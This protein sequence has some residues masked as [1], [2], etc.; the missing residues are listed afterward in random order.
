MSRGPA[1][2]GPDPMHNE[3]CLP[4]ARAAL[5]GGGVTSPG[6]LTRTRGWE[7]SHPARLETGLTVSHCSRG[8]TTCPGIRGRGPRPQNPEAGAA[9]PQQCGHTAPVFSQACLFLPRNGAPTVSGVITTPFF[10][11]WNFLNFLSFAVTMDS[12]GGCW[13]EG[14]CD[15]ILQLS[16]FSELFFLQ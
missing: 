9:R 11:F 8:S 14:G 15:S 6:S 1:R 5:G 12:Q 10:N 3:H 16:K 7:G 13:W 4:E 2:S